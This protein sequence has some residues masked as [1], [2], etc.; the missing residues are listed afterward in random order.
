[1][2][3][4]LQAP[5]FLK[6]FLV[7][8]PTFRITSMFG[9]KRGDKY[10][11]GIDIGT[12]IGI[13]IACPLNGVIKKIANEVKGYGKHVVVRYEIMTGDYIDIYFAH[14]SSI[15]SRI[16]LGDDIKIGEYLGK[17]GN[18]G[19][20]TGPH[21][22]LEMRHI[23]TPI[24]PI[25]FLMYHKLIIQKTNKVYGKG[26]VYD[27]S[28]P[29]G[30]MVWETDFV[31]ISD[32]IANVVPQTTIENATEKFD[33]ITPNNTTASMRAA[34]GI[35]GI[36][37]L[38][39]D[40]SISN[41]QVVDSSI[42]S[43]Q[44]S[45]LNFFHKVCQEPMVEF[46]G[47]TYGDQY[48]LIAR[49]PPFDKEGIVNMMELAML[50]IN[51]DDIVS[52]SLDWNTEGIYS[53]YQY[54]P[55]YQLQLGEF[56]LSSLVPAVFF[57]EYASIW[58]SKPL[59]VESNYYTWVGRGKY[60][61]DKNK[62]NDDNTIQAAF[63]DLQ[64]L[65]ECN[66]YAP[67]TRRGTI[68]LNGDRRYKKGTLVLHT[69]G[70]IFYIDSVTNE[71]SISSNGITRKTVLGVSRG[72]YQEFVEGVDGHNYFNI[73]DFGTNK[74]KITESNWQKVMSKWKVNKEVF[75]YFMRKEQLITHGR[76]RNM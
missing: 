28:V 41:K 72:M 68:T 3:A 18:S 37:K 26:G 40:S 50:E 17:T 24:D 63:S 14:L 71:W 36:V 53:W 16:S 4:I 52:T 49:K 10:H 61:S 21:L 42:A 57:P 27:T 39:M 55:K 69:S 33:V 74:E 34:A 19:H 76:Q 22:H 38:V 7:G 54:M 29:G 5:V 51:P 62:T 66:A 30:Y 67:F 9:A 35:W 47:D 44:G 45:L 48:Y 8:Y 65:I 6:N 25:D 60:N 13:S 15:S 59:A 12:P 31:S 11:K 20:S 70:E 58:G 23:S 2:N 1:M 32:K 46:F 73:I 75:G 56:E 43:Q 64:Y